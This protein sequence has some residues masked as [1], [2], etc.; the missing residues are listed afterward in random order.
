MN[1]NEMKNAECRRARCI[2]MNENISVQAQILLLDNRLTVPMITIIIFSINIQ[3]RLL[4]PGG[5]DRPK[6]EISRI[7]MKETETWKITVE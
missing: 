6:L 1:T 5:T 3:G 4:Q 2:N 7:Q